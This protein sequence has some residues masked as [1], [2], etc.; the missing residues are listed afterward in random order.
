MNPF[1]KHG[2]DHLSASALNLWS[3]S[4]RLYCIRYLARVKDQ[5]SPA[6]IRGTAVE[7]ALLHILHGKSNPEAIALDAYMQNTGGEVDN[8]VIEAERALIPGM[9]EQC[10][11]WKQPKGFVGSQ[12]RIEHYLDGISIPVIGFLDFAFDEV[13]VDLK[14]TKACPSKPRPE[15][16]RQVSIYRAA[17][18]KPGR[19]LYVTDK[20]HA[21]FEVDDAM[22]GEALGH[23]TEAANSLGR[24]LGL[25]RDAAE[26]IESLPMD[27]DN[28]RWSPTAEIAVKQ[29]LLEAF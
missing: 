10:L 11:R 3:S 26:A 2:I 24:Y 29:L 7:N 1:K 21:E 6:A 17:R 12:L 27:R 22:M 9:V 8:D 15:H 19:L 23:L 5:G 13:D 14:T 16:V 4:P 28:F 25:V 18:K 20:R